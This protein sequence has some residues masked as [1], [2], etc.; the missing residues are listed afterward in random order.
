MSM[1]LGEIFVTKVLKR[2][3]DIEFNQTCFDVS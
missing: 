3:L 1:F 2:L